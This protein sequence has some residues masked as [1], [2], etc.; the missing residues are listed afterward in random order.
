ML[1]NMDTRRPTLD[2]FPP[3]NKNCKC[4]DCYGYKKYIKEGSKVDHSAVQTKSRCENDLFHQTSVLGESNSSLADMST[5]NYSFQS[6][7]INPAQRSVSTGNIPTIGTG[8]GVFGKSKSASGFPT[9]YSECTYK[10]TT[11]NH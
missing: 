11:S 2:L 1:V 6:E 5:F 4:K 9:N 3:S 7:T 8:N 10:F